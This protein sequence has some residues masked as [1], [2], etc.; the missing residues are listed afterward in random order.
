VVIH[1]QRFFVDW[2][3]QIQS[4]YFSIVK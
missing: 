4:T 2:K 3:W 1:A